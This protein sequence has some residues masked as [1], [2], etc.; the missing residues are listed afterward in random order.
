MKCPAKVKQFLWCFTH[1]SLAVKRNL[2][3][4]GVEVDI[5]C[6]MCNRHIEDSGHLFINC[7]QV[8]ALWRELFL[9][10]QRCLLTEKHSASEVMAQILLMDEEVQTKV[11]LLFWLWW[12][13]RNVVR[14]GERRRTMSDL[15]YVVNKISVEYLELHKASERVPTK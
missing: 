12:Q 2:E 6:V 8:K 14:E 13:E 7:K 11:V 10:Q 15:A 1:N 5:R 3:R 4:R 9:E